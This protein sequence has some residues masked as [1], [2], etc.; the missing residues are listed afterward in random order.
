MTDSVRPDASSVLSL[1][2]AGFAAQC[3]RVV[4][5]ESGAESTGG[6]LGWGLPDGMPCGG[7]GGCAGEG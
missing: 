3:E 6:T 7:F 5:L 4:S 1:C 2:T